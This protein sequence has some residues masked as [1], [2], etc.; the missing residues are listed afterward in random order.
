VFYVRVLLLYNISA[1]VL[2]DDLGNALI[3][4][5][6]LAKVIEEFS[7]SM[8][9]MTSFFAGSVRHDLWSLGRCSITLIT[10]VLFGNAD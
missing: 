7:D 3:T 10:C 1:L 5:F 6:G 9:L 8:Q 2:V 4:D